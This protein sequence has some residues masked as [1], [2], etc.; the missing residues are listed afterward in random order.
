[1]KK[2]EKSMLTEVVLTEIL[3]VYGHRWV[4]ERNL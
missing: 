3:N 2:G 1:M 4:E